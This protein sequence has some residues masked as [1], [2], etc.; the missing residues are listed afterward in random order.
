KLMANDNMPAVASDLINDYATATRTIDYVTLSETSVETPAP[1]T[2]EQLAAYLAEHQAEFRTVETRNVKLLD[3]S[4]ASL[5][6]TKTISEEEIAAEFE[7]TKATLVRPERRTIEQVSLSTP[8]L[9]AQFEAGLVDGTDFGTLIAEANLTPSGLGTLA[10][11]E[12]T[13]TALASTAF[14]LDEGGYAVIEGIGGT[15]AIH[16]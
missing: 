3:L 16:V 7:A 4:M 12:I 8:E 1:P 13:D 14:S 10:Q 6:G 11:S 9:V 2:E 5:A 15:R